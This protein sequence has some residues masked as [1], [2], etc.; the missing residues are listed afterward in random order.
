[1]CLIFD[2]L[3]L[4]LTVLVIFLSTFLEDLTFKAITVITEA[5][6]FNHPKVR[7]VPALD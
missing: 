1:M 4:H 5:T 3:T 2:V 7:P 6:V